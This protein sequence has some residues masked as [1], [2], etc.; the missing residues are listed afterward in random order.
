MVWWIAYLSKQNYRYPIKEIPAQ[1]Q[2]QRQYK[3]VGPSLHLITR[4]NKDHLNILLKPFNGYIFK[5]CLFTG[6][7]Q[8]YCFT[9]S[10]TRKKK[11]RSI[12][13]SSVIMFEST[14]YWCQGIRLKRILFNKIYKYKYIYI[15]IYIYIYAYYIYYIYILY[16]IVIKLFTEKNKTFYSLKYFG[17]AFISRFLDYIFRLYI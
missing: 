2:K 6:H 13:P 3:N 9:L 8:L 15:Y 1:S 14:S 16:I 7:L 4:F 11:M 5:N 17:I 12:Y 10:S